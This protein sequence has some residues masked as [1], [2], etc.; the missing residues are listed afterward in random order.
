MGGRWGFSDFTLLTYPPLPSP[1][2]FSQATTSKNESAPRG[3]TCLRG[4]GDGI[5]P[6]QAGWLDWGS[7][8]RVTRLLRSRGVLATSEL[9]EC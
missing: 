4:R 2:S 3:L 9:R 5:V 1:D 7:P 6:P 8:V